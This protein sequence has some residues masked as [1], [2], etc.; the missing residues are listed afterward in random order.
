MP[1]SFFMNER[2]LFEPKPTLIDWV[3][4][5]ARYQQAYVL[6]Q[7]QWDATKQDKNISMIWD[8]MKHIVDC[9]R[10]SYDIWRLN[11]RF[12]NLRYGHFL[13]ETHDIRRFYQ[14]AHFG[15]YSDSRTQYNHAVEGATL[16]RRDQIHLTKIGYTPEEIE[17][18]A[19]GVEHHSSYRYT[20]ENYA[21]KF[22]RDMDKLALM[23]EF[24]H[25]WNVN[26]N[27]HGLY[28]VGE[29]SD[30]AFNQFKHQ[31]PILNANVH[32]TSDAMLRMAGWQFDINFPE[33]KQLIA[34]EYL[35]PHIL[36][37]IDRTDLLQY[38]IPE[39]RNAE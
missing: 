17:M 16:I 14:V 27:G 23:R 26:I 37:L 15:D 24:D 22:A 31:E 13:A 18:L 3:Y 19:D 30:D 9:D 36:H 6:Q 32:T 38:S 7:T 4:E 8:K 11:P 1:G 29:V 39:V 25:T 20:G 34:K 21:A 33:T 28:I 2:R 35:V 10:A 5:E 12:H